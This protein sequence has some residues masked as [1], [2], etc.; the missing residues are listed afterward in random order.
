MGINQ[1]T[2]LQVI[3]EFSHMSLTLAFEDSTLG[4]SI[5]ISAKCCTVMHTPTS[6]FY[7]GKLHCKMIGFKSIDNFA[8]IK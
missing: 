3:S 6:C 4:V 1:R 2:S 8:I 7:V 5:F